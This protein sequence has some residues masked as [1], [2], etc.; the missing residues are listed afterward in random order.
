MGGHNSSKHSAA[1]KD[2]SRLSVL[3]SEKCDRAQTKKLSAA[4][5]E[6]WQ[7]EIKAIHTSV[8][9]YHDHVLSPLRQ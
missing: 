6:A 1:N 7:K 3:S 8:K 2:H 5:D 9:C 4:K